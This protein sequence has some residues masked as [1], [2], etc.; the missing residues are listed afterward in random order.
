MTK[1][2]AAQE[3]L[4]GTRA[5]LR[6]VGE[7]RRARRLPDERYA[8]VRRA[9]LQYGKRCCDYGLAMELGD[10]WHTVSEIR[11]ILEKCIGRSD[12][13]VLTMNDVSDKKLRE[14]L[15]EMRIPF[16]R[17]RHIAGKTFLAP[18]PRQA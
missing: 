7:F 5:L 17:A 16:R 8:P 12:G 11:S 1:T 18:P 3:L 9:L 2:R 6:N 10:A 14:L 13:N 4:Y 15:R